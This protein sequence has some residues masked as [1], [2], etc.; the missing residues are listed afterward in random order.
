MLFKKI[1]VVLEGK[2]ESVKKKIK[3]KKL[4]SFHFFRC[5]FEEKWPKNLSGFIFISG[6]WRKKWPKNLSGFV[7]FLS[8]FWE[9]SAKKNLSGFFPKWF[10]NPKKNTDL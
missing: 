5:I 1:E 2:I 8:G 3:E 4:S 10:E 7:F 9:N 6:F